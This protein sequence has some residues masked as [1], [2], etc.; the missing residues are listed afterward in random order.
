MFFGCSSLTSITIPDGVTRISDN[1]FNACSSLESIEI[2][3][4]VTGIE[5]G[6]LANCT[7]LTTIN[8]KGTVTQWN[9][10]AKSDWNRNTGDYTII[11]TDGNIAKDGT[12]TMD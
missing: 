3:D 10:I 9:A 1:A 5:Y 4:S 12:V 2:P 8:Y 7:S 6:A 11:C